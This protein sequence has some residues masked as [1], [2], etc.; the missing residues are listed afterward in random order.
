MFPIAPVHASSMVFRVRVWPLHSSTF[1]IPRYDCPLFTTQTS[2]ASTRVVVTD[3][4]IVVD[5]VGEVVADV[6]GVW[7]TVVVCV[8][9]VSD[10]VP[11]V[12]GVDFSHFSNSPLYNAVIAPPKLLTVS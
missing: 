2:S 12:V 11:V 10:V 3:V 4:V 1:L 5:V 9:V 6:V 8:V 7:V